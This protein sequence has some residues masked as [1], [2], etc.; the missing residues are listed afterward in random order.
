MCP[1][2]L[3]LACKPPILRR[4][5]RRGRFQVVDFNQKLKDVGFTVG[6]RHQTDL[7]RDMVMV[8]RKAVSHL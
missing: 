7:G 6:N 1:Q 2:Q 5:A 4:T 3:G 8:S